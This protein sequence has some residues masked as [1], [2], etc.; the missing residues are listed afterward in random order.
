MAESE[1]AA[2]LKALVYLAVSNMVEL[3]LK[4][5][6]AATPTFIASLVEL[7]FNQIIG[8]GNDLEQ[9]AHHA[10]R[11]IVS[12]PDVFM[13]TRKNK[14]LTEALHKFYKSL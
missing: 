9:F 13:I 8:L 4:D 12:P 10:G 3:E 5:K 11:D 7:V 6:A 14:H 1:I 2:H